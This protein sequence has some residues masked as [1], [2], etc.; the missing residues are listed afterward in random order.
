MRS[1]ENDLC[2]LLEWAKLRAPLK[3]PPV[4][5]YHQR[6]VSTPYIKTSLFSR[7]LFSEEFLKNFR[8]PHRSVA[9]CRN[10]A[11]ALLLPSEASNWKQIWKLNAANYSFESIVDE[12]NRQRLQSAKMS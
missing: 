1:T 9:L 12:T 2:D 11:K 8:L 5:A 7:L 4:I 6:D 3:F 10:R